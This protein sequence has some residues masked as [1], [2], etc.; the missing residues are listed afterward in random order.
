M[1]KENIMLNKIRVIIQ[2]VVF[3]AVCANMG[4]AA[5]AVEGHRPLDVAF[6]RPATFRV[7][8]NSTGGIYQ[9][10]MEEGILIGNGRLGAVIK[11]DPKRE[12]LRISESTLWTGTT[13]TRGYYENL[14]AFQ[15]VGDVFVEMPHH[16]DY[17][18]F[19]CWLD[20]ESSLSVQTY[21]VDG[22]T[23]RREA[24]SSYPDKV[25]VMRFTASKAGMLTGTVKFKDS[26]DGVNV[27]SGNRITTATSLGDSDNKTTYET[28]I[29]V[30]NEGGSQNPHLDEYGDG[31]D[32]K[33]CD[34][35]TLFIVIGTDHVLD[36]TSYTHTGGMYHG[37]HPHQRLTADIDAAVKV[38][39]ETLKSRHIADYKSVYD[40]CTIYLGESTPAQK[41]KPANERRLDAIDTVDLELDAINFQLGRYLMISASRPGSLYPNSQGIWQ[42]SNFM[43]WGARYT[44]DL[45]SQMPFWAVESTNT[46]ESHKPMFETLKAFI[47]LWKQHMVGDPEIAKADGTTPRG[48]VMRSGFN[49][50]GGTAFWWDKANSGWY[51][52]HM[53]EHY[54]FG[55]DKEYLRTMTYPMMKEVVEFHE[56]TLKTLPDGRLVV[57]MCWSPE[58]GPWEDGVSYC[59]EIVWELFDNY[60][61]AADVLGVD[62]E[63]RDRIEQMRDK[64][65]RP[66]IGN[67][68]QVLEWFT[69]KK[70]TNPNGGDDPEGIDYKGYDTPEDQHRHLSHLWF[71]FPGT[72]VSPRYTPEWAEATKTTLK[73][74]EDTSNSWN[75]SWRACIYARLHEPD[76]AYY[77]LQ[78]G[79]KY[80]N[81]NLFVGKTFQFDGN[82]A[83]TAAIADMIMQSHIK[84]EIEILPCLPKQWPNGYLK[85]LR[86]RGGF[87]VDVEWKD[88]KLVSAT[89]RST[90]GNK[91]KL[92]FGEKVLDLNLALNESATFDSNLNRIK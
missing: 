36:H 85:G 6:D 1:G 43:K 65:A 72:Q 67:F 90:A 57:P 23:Y 32:F 49:I 21:T 40:R 88:G 74:K 38:P 45:T 83:M 62:K 24:F 7:Q 75:Y 79:Y 31:I 56:D 18:N 20:L 44:P 87:E 26:H 3:I 61:K 59:Q 89:L 41:A 71:V 76:L 2:S 46:A 52:H 10:L 25:M 66:G 82:P 58:H 55:Q 19:R 73:Y 91:A 60:V 16:K 29:V 33:N 51:A 12:L 50:R 84:D 28:Q 39:Y 48:W 64:V 86:A 17:S 69:D 15:T 4:Y 13:Y 53:W 14:G 22:V 8:N 54:L 78:K 70:G 34:V 27:V 5:S 9:T 63:Y 77:Q 47:P 92:R 30:L 11:N 35:I 80:L 37:E 68:G 81:H 42:D